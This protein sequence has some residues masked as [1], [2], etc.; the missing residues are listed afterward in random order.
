[1][2]KK[3]GGTFKSSVIYLS[4][5]HS[6]FCVIFYAQNNNLSPNIINIFELS[7]VSLISLGKTIFYIYHMN[8]IFKTSKFINCFINISPIDNN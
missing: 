1:M 2:L 5:F 8:K 7:V 6:T 4:I 3:L